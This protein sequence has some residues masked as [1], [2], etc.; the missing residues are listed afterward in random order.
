[1]PKFDAELLI[2]FGGLDDVDILVADAAPSG[3]LSAALA[4]RGRRGLDAV[5]V[6]LTANPS[7]IR[8]IILDEPLRPGAV[9]TA[10]TVR[11]DAEAGDQRHH[12][13]QGRARQPCHPAPRPTDSFG[14]ALERRASTRCRSPCGER[15]EQI[16]RSPTPT[17]STPK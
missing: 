2:S 16:S 14:E 8:M 15:R 7:S 10:L 17:G 6:T 5:I 11:E 9:Q 4:M 1:M 3:E 13:L 12:L